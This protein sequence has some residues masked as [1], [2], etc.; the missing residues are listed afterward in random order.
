MSTEKCLKVSNDKRP[1]AERTGDR[2]PK[3]PRLGQP[4]NVFENV[5]KKRKNSLGMLMNSNLSVRKIL[6]LCDSRV[7]H[8]GG[9][10]WNVYSP[11]TNRMAPNVWWTGLILKTDPSSSINRVRDAMKEKKEGGHPSIHTKAQ[12]VNVDALP[13][14]GIIT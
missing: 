3:L 6:G 4:K 14:V 12:G 1:S 11:N 5:E 8:L 9:D 2:L 13:D 7:I 10:V